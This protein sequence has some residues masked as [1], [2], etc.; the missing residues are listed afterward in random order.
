MQPNPGCESDTDRADVD[1]DGLARCEELLL[2][3]STEVYDTDADGVPDGLEL[4]VG[5]DPSKSDALADSDLDGVRNG[6][7]IRAH[8]GIGFEEAS[9]RPDLAY[10]YKT[11]EL[12]INEDGQRCYNFRVKNVQ[13]GTPLARQGDAEAFGRNEI[14]LYMAQAPFDD[15]NDFGSYKVACVHARYV[16]PDFKDPPT[17]LVELV[18][19]DFKEPDLLDVSSDCVGLTTPGGP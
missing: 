3:T 9:Q 14:L 16:A 11:E 7:E 17:G 10:R 1:F 5:T 4:V 18:P 12:G 6:D 13:L 15:P 19:E 2:R 8:T